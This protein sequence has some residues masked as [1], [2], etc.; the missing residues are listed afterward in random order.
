MGNTFNYKISPSRDLNGETRVPG[1]KSISHRAIILAAIAKG[2]SQINGFL[3][4]ADN[5][6][7]LEALQQLGV[8]IVYIADEAIV[9]VTGVGMDGLTPAPDVLDLGNSGTGIRLLTGLLSAQP[10][11]STLTGDASL[12]SRPMQRIVEPLRLMGADIA[13]A[14]SNT[15]PLKIKKVPSLSG[16]KYRLPVASAQVKSCLLLAGLYAKGS[17]TIVEPVPTRDHTERLLRAFGAAITVHDDEITINSGVQ[18]KAININ[19]S[20]D[21]SSAAFFIV[22]AT[23]TPGSSV[24]LKNVGINPRRMGVIYLLQKMGADIKL[25]NESI[26]S[27]E[28]VADIQVSYSSLQGIEIPVEYVSATID[29]F[30]ILFIAAACARGKTTL[31]GAKELRVKET[32]RIAAMATGL[33]KLGI[34]AKS[35]PDGLIIEGGTLQGG[36]VESYGDHRVAMAFAIAG[37]VSKTPVTVRDCHQVATSFPGFEEIAAEIGIKVEVI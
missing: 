29:E 2:I 23:I 21:I 33:Q 6:A 34:V 15:P 20:A 10:F 13:M 1:D 14:A 16:I 18:L 37:C 25:M 5:L 22:A 31:R 36:E 27:C 26:Q 7:T 19:I 17:T 3:M 24:T 12:C 9:R 11:D 8:S 35:L 30:P 32:D 4:G 28:P